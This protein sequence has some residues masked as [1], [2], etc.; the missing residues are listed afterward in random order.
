MPFYGVTCSAE[1]SWEASFSDFR[2]SVIF[3]M[4]AFRHL[5]D[6]ITGPPVC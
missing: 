3:L 6:T 1:Y 5:E 2:G 4:L